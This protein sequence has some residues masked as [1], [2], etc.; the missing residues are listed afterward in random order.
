MN[1]AI[2]TAIEWFG[3]IL[4]M[5]MFIRAIMSWFPGGRRSFIYNGLSVITEPFVS[6]VRKLIQKSPLGGGVLDFS[7]II[8]LVLIRVITPVLSNLALRIPF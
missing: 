7:F 4:T 3:W 2:A 1:V 5:C 6:P 8:V